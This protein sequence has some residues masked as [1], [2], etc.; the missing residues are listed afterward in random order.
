LLVLVLR[1][2]DER[3]LGAQKGGKERQ[4]PGSTG[5]GP[6]DLLS[7]APGGVC[8]LHKRTY[9]PCWEVRASLE[10]EVF[11]QACLE[12]AVYQEERKR[13]AA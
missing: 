7:R 2:L 12:C 1:E 9:Q 13:I 6:A 11:P 3:W 10:G 4:A 8:P 5:E